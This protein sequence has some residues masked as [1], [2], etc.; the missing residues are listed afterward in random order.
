ASPR[1][2]TR[3]GFTITVF[4]TGDE[5]ARAAASRVTSGLRQKQDLMIVTATGGSPTRTYEFLAGDH[6]KDPALFRGLRVHKLDEWG[7]LDA[8]DP[9]S[10]EAY[11]QEHLLAPLQIDH[12]RYFGF[13]PNPPDPV[14]E[15]RRVSQWL[16]QNGPSDI[17]I[18]GLGLNGHLALNEPA[19][20]LP[21]F[22]HKAILSEESRS[23]PMLAIARKPATYGMGLGLA[24]I[25]ASKQILLLVNGAAKAK[26]LR[27]LI[28]ER[29]VY[30]QHPA[31][32][33]W[34]H[35]NVACLCDEAAAAECDLNSLES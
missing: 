10:C 23:H 8:D 2:A 21:P 30:T 34:L 7:G 22:S 16:Y 17:C 12:D 26:Q 6:Q 29:K 14:G 31:S 27:R 33:L 4:R 5:L 3:G 9:G 1:T 32:F 19:D 18:L 20:F 15:C 35:P 28:E 24:E 25:F 11:L 13:R